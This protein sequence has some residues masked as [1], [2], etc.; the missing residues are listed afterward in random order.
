MRNRLLILAL[1]I[2][3]VSM[4]STASAVDRRWL[5]A[6]S[7]N[8]NVTTNWFATGIPSGDS[9]YIDYAPYALTGGVGNFTTTISD[10]YTI[11]QLFSRANITHSGG[12]LTIQNPGSDVKGTYTLNGGNLNVLA[13]ATFGPVTFNSG[14]INGNGH[15]IT[16]LFMLDTA[17]N[18]QFQG[19][20]GVSGNT[21]FKGGAVYAFGSTLTN[22]GTFQVM[23]DLI[24]RDGIINNSGILEKTAGAG[25]T[26][27]NEA[28]SG[29][30]A[31]VNNTGTVRSSSGTLALAGSGTST[32]T[33]SASGSGKVR[34]AAGSPVLN[35]GAFLGPGD[36]GM[37]G[38]T[39]TANAG[40]NG[41][42]FALEG[43]NLGGSGLVLNGKLIQS[44]GNVTGTVVA[45]G[46]MNQNGGGDR[47]IYGS[48]TAGG[49][50]T[51]TGGIVYSFNGAFT[52][53][54][55]MQIQGDLTWR[56][57]TLTNNGTIAKTSGVGTAILNT[58]WSGGTILTKNQGTMTSS[59]G[60][61]AFGANGLHTGG[62]FSGTGSGTVQFVTGNHTITG[63]TLATGSAVNGATLTVTGTNTLS[64]TPQFLAGT[65]TGTGKFVGSALVFTG[66]SSRSLSGSVENAGTIYL[67]ASNTYAY[68]S[69]WK[70][71]GIWDVRADG[72]L[73]DGVLLNTG[74][75]RKTAGA[76]T[77][78]FN[79]AWSGGARGVSNQGQVLSTSGVLALHGSG[80]HSGFFNGTGGGI[81][82]FAEGNQSLVT[83]MSTGTGDVRVTGA[84]VSIVNDVS[85]Q[86][87]AVDGGNLTGSANMTCTDRFTQRGGT[88]SGTGTLNMFGGATFTTSNSK[89]VGRKVVI[90]GNS[91]FDQGTIYAYTGTITN[92]GTFHI[93]GDLSIR[94]G[95]FNNEGVL[96]KTAG[97]GSAF[98]GE[99][100]NGGPTS[101]NNKGTVQSLSGVLRP[102]NSGTHS[103]AFYGSGGGTFQFTNGTHVMQ[104]NATM[105][106]GCYL[107]GATM[108]LAGAVTLDGSPKM[109]SGTLNGVGSINGGT[110]MVDGAFGLSADLTSFSTIQQNSTIYSYNGTI[111]NKATYIVNGPQ[112][113]RDGWFINDALIQR[114]N[115]GGTSYF[116]LGWSG[117]PTGFT[118]NGTLELLD[119]NVV[120]TA[121]MSNYSAGTFGG[122]TIIVNDN[123]MLSTQV[124][125][126]VKNA[127]RI[128]LLGVN[129]G[130]RDNANQDFLRNMVTNTGSIIYSG[131]R[132]QSVSGSV[133]NQGDIT[134]G[135]G[136]T[137]TTSPAASTYTQSAGLTIIDGTLTTNGVTLSGGSFRGKGTVGSAINQSNGIL[138]PGNP[139]G[140]LTTG[141]VT[142]TGG[143]YSAR[144]GGY[145]VGQIGKL[146]GAAV[147]VA[148]KLEVSVLPGMVVQ[149]NDTFRI[150]TGT[151]RA[152]TFTTLPP[153][154]DWSV[155]Y[156]G[157]FVD[158]KANRQIIGQAVV[159]GKV[160]LKSWNLS[161]TTIPVTIQLK[162]AGNVLDTKIVNLDAS[163][164]YSFVTSVGG[165][166]DIVAKASHWLSDK[167][168]NV[169]IGDSAVTDVNFS[170]ING[171]CNGDNTVDFFDFLVMSA[172]Y[173]ST[174]GDP[175]YT[176]NIGADLNGD[177]SID[178]FDYFVMSEAW[179]LQ[180]ED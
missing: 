81:V 174:T 3:A 109:L 36:V 72:F 95:I 73:R 141:N 177:G 117:G 10:S 68:S 63:C 33:F 170:L 19:S 86:K 45:N 162:Q 79:E 85:V 120:M 111:R 143:Q 172:G 30:A 54:G 171:D 126:P 66:G 144:I 123:C 9:V 156:G 25:T 21:Q 29:G 80:T 56:D 138:A 77:M 75:L 119:G 137:F 15:T 110:L 166:Y 76:G 132:S 150:I 5:T 64:G 105:G 108:T 87:F 158:I 18:K 78:S 153:A 100:W 101:F 14:N 1:G 16:G 130:L 50:S 152:G 23:G 136:G 179:E 51:W 129:S 61:L 163:G 122:G 155:I 133:N 83:G 154:A 62:T 12:I 41:Q 8:W 20:W 114:V 180:G 65:I 67:D 173:E 89:A 44:G 148:G 22:S 88:L 176:A 167:Q 99:G 55:S 13:N 113:H 17:P 165:T 159:S 57:G 96:Q 135:T 26:T 118:N 115:G 92:Q 38:G 145:A 151:S 11:S 175:A 124:P 59:S 37:Y 112:S 70:N 34:F 39:L 157:T 131:G 52:N 71:S 43:G 93:A 102:L 31:G 24:Y 82:T 97:A 84:T 139:T 6:T 48:L 127:S 28:W 161:V 27:M 74:I 58:P 147:T 134:M 40:V 47:F 107:N 169:F 103:G 42:D 149:P 164:N 128:R 160:D 46:G 140:T 146:A 91:L 125:P 4:S 49:T 7:G 90:L 35:A 121:G 53:S 116:N 104:T 106:T 60:V 2:A 32:G 168:S 69:S 98:I 178:L 142:M 94:D